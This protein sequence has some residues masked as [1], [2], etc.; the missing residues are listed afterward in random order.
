MYGVYC[1]DYQ[2]PVVQVSERRAATRQRRAG[3]SVR[4]S[5]GL[6]PVC[7][8]CRTLLPLRSAR[9]RPRLP[10]G[11]AEGFEPP[12]MRVVL[13]DAL[14]PRTALFETRVHLHFWLFIF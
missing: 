8:S 2:Y 9:A 13:S 4:S 14:A 1:M 7:W 3:C 5:G 10:R 12:C 6:E 11:S